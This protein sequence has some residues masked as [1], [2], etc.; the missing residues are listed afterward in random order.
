MGV[1]RRA[2]GLLPRRALSAPAFAPERNEIWYTDGN[3]GFFALQ[4]R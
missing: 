3:C 1:K 4:L 2:L